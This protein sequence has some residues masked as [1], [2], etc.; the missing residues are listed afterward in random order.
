MR[1]K[2]LI[3]L[4]LGIASHPIYF[5]NTLAAQQNTGQHEILE[6]I[7]IGADWLL[8]AQESAPDGHGY[9]RRYSL[10]TGWDKCYTE[11]TG[12]II[13][14]LLGVSRF[15]DN[16]IYKESAYKAGEW[17]IGV[18]SQD[19]SFADI[20]TNR[21]Q[22]FDTGQVLLGLNRMY[23]ETG[24]ERYLDSLVKA[25]RWLIDVQ[26]SDGSWKRFA[27]NN[28]PHAYYTRVAAALIEAGQITGIEEYITAGVR[29]LEWT[30][31][32]RKANGY[33]RFSE[34]RDGE[35]AILHTIIYVLEGYSKAYDLTGDKRWADI[36]I[37]SSEVLYEVAPD[38]GLLF[39]QYDPDWRATNREYCVTGLAQFAGI[40]MDV[41][42]INGDT[43]FRDVG[44][45]IINFLSNLQV[46]R[47]KDIKGALQSSVP[48]WGYYGGMEFF[49]W[50]MKFYLDAV[51]K[52]LDSIETR[53]SGSPHDDLT[54]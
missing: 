43:R 35:D 54:S 16:N 15:L 51:L 44:E 49:N 25:S 38:D 33:F 41:M 20:D 19:G 1:V 26:E 10:I 21:P 46:K 8:N 29:N 31:N 6:S 45:R 42:K 48:I 13:P 11:T 14:T 53:S 34:F 39:S 3:K 50:N 22:V 7:R 24:C 30:L 47:G 40:C 36:L 18:Q 32:Q 23:Q 37:E 2:Q 17:L 12:Y 5:S 9:S 52:Y 27:Y 4:C 28:R